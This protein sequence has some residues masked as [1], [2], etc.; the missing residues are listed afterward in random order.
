M[1]MGYGKNQSHDL[2]VH[3]G[4]T[5]KHKYS[6]KVANINDVIVADVAAVVVGRKTRA[7]PLRQSALLCAMLDVQSERI[8]CMRIFVNCQICD[9][10]FEFLSLGMHKNA[11]FN[12][13]TEKR[14]FGTL[15]PSTCILMMHMCVYLFVC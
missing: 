5:L 14:H 8:I 11:E 13:G 3:D 9:A 12:S 2:V 7:A 15:E 6:T 10:F 1:F 4:S